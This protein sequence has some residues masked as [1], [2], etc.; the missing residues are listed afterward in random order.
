MTKEA[1]IYNGV[2]TDFSLNVVGK[3]DGYMQ[4]K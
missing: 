3:L 1:E 2:K 4:K